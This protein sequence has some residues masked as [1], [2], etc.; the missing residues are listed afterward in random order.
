MFLEILEVFKDCFTF[1]YTSLDKIKLVGDSSVFDFLIVFFLASVFLPLFASVFG[2]RGI[3]T[4]ASSTAGV[5][6]S[7]NAEA[8]WKAQQ[9]QREADRKHKESYAYYKENRARSEAYSARYHAEK[10]N[11]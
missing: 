5:L 10:K 11:R 6:D 1:A 8:E 9:A 4:S 3:S 2:G 7:R